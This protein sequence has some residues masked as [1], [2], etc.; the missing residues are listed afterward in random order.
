MSFLIECQGLFGASAL[1]VLEVSVM[2]CPQLLSLVKACNKK[3]KSP[4]LGV[5][6]HIYIYV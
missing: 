5:S 6:S 3:L 1:P 2:L 4:T